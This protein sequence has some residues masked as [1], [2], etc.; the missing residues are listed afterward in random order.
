MR[1]RYGKGRRRGAALLLVLGLTAV[2]WAPAATVTEKGYAV[3]GDQEGMTAEPS[4]AAFWEY[5]TLAAGQSREDGVLR[6]VNNGKA[7][8]D[9]RLQTVELPYGNQEAL[10]YLDAL[11]LRVTDGKTVLY[12]G[13]YTR[14]M[15][16]DGLKLEVQGLAGGTEKR[17]QV[18]L[19]ADFRY[20]G[21]P[22]TAAVQIPWLFAAS[23][24]E[25]QRD[26]EAPRAQG[27]LLVIVCAAGVLVVLC[28]VA[29]ALNLT[30][31]VV[32]KKK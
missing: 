6:L 7:A 3:N 12:D 16:K 26:V 24:A 5:P 1:G 27:K 17:W 30:K 19:Y 18:A 4:A 2:L 28:I 32:R 22:Q 29:G 25:V 20:E 14:V 15:E 23:E 13:P 8:L 10:A 31:R 11:R 9:F 21:D